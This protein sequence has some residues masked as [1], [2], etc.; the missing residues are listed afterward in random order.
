MGRCQTQGSDRVSDWTAVE[1]QPKVMDPALRQ[2]HSP[3]FSS[4][5]A[6]DSGV[7]RNLC[8]FRYYDGESGDW[9]TCGREKGHAKDK[10][11]SWVK[12]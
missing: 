1:W 2:K 9:F 7:T 8:G 5:S 12:E 3:D 10:H 4:G 6:E 11:G